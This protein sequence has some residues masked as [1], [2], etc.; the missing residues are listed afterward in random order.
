MSKSHQKYNVI[1][2]WDNISIWCINH[3]EPV[4]ME[5]LENTEMIKTPF[6]ACS[7]NTGTGTCANRMNL[8]DYQGVILAFLDLIGAEPFVNFTNYIFTYKGARHKLEVKVLK[9]QDDDIRL[10]IK[11][12]TILG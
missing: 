12:R 3:D 7:T 6:Y 8:D 4:K 2:V 1:N 10:G 9:H 5:I 11:N